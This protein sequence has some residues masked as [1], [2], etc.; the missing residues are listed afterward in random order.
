VKVWV[1][2]ERSTSSGR[3]R[4]PERADQVEV[5]ELTAVAHTNESVAIRRY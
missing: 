1:V 3:L 2:D 4:R 5:A